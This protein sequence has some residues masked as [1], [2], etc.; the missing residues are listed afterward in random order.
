MLSLF[1]GMHAL[2]GVGKNAVPEKPFQVR[3]LLEGV[4]VALT[5]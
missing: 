5:R 4:R 2:D 1:L 3:E